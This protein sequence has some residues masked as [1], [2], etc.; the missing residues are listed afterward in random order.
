MYWTCVDPKTG[1][2]CGRLHR[3]KDGAIRCETA[4][5]N[6]EIR[7]KGLTSVESICVGGMYGVPRHSQ[8][9]VDLVGRGL[10]PSGKGRGWDK[11]YEAALQRCAAIQRRR[12]GYV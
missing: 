12:D 5:Q 7:E 8:T 10:L 3:K 4:I 11:A 6:R 9:W 1:K 2:G